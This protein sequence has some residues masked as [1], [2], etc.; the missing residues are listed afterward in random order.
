MDISN[1]TLGCVYVVL[2]TTW[3]SINL[4]LGTELFIMY[5]QAK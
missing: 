2:A 4:K 5:L 3:A 1:G